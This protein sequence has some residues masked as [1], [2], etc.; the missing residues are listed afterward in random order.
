MNAFAQGK[1]NDLKK[2]KNIFCY[3]WNFN[4]RRVQGV[5][6]KHKT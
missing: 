1:K 2:K 5:G 4:K 3:S 6:E